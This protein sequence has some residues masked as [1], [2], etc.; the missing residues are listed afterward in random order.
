MRATPT[1]NERNTATV[2]D[3]A[4]ARRPSAHPALAGRPLAQCALA[5]R[6]DAHRTFAARPLAGRRFVRFAL[7]LAVTAT[8][9]CTASWTPTT[10]APATALQWPLPPDAA[11]VSYTHA[12]TG[13]TRDTSVG[14]VMEAVVFGRDGSGDGFQ[15]PVSFATAADGRVAVAD[16]GCS[17]VHLFLP[18]TSKYLRLVGSGSEAM[19][20]P[21]GVAFDDQAR[22]YVSDSAGALFAFDAEGKP[23]FVSRKAGEQPFER[24]TGLAWSPERSLLYV[25]DTK[26][27]AVRAFDTDGGFRFSFGGR[28]AGE[29]QLNFPTHIAHAPSGELFVTDALNFRIA[30]FDGDGRPR[31][32]FGRHGDGSGDFAMPKGIA[33]DADGVIYVV[34]A[35]FDNVQLF[36]RRGELLLTVGNRGVGFGEFWLPSGAFLSQR[37]DLY[38]CDTYNRRVQVFRVGNGYANATT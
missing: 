1:K 20:S 2:E 19:V 28:G 22:L 10:V 8:A 29:G 4:L 7:T 24:P 16:S 14:T 34:D 11:R 18:A 27:H 36:N 25:V 37:G 38:V 13:L 5:A 15:L 33:V 26:A 12:L 32:S 6:P 21:V 17:C 9:G 31:G 3:R 35:I 23:R 30:I